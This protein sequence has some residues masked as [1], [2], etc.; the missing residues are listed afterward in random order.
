M[1]SLFDTRSMCYPLAVADLG[2]M[3]AAAMHS[4]QKSGALAAGLRPSWRR[5]RS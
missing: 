5:R 2:S 4:D 3:T 1:P